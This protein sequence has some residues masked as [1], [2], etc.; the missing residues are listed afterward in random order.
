VRRHLDGGFELDDDRDRIDRAA[1]HDFL[2]NESYWARGRPR[3]TM[4][5]LIETAERV[6]GLYRGADLVGFSRTISDGHTRSYLADVYVVPEVRGQG[7]G[8]ELVRFSVDE[9]PYAATGWLLHTA[10]A[11]ELYR[12]FGFEPPGDRLLERKRPL[13]GRAG[14]AS[15]RG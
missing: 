3:Q 1:V 12:K 15:A 7:L 5:D 6:V 2:A 14:A 9:G 11:H 8:V 10:D 13:P 4:D